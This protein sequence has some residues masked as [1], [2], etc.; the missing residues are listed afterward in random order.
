MAQPRRILIVRLSHLGDV[1]HALPV[2]HALRE[3]HPDAEFGW[4][5]QPEFASLLEGLPGLEQLF[6]FERQKGLS[7]WIKIGREIR[8]WKP[9]L[10]V[11]CQGNLKSAAVTRIS[12]APR[13]AG[14]HRY[15]WREQAGARVLTETAYRVTKQPIHALDR[16][17]QLARRFASETKLRTDPDLTKAELDRGR[18]AWREH[19]GETGAL[20]IHLSTQSDVRSWPTSSAAQLARSAAEAGRA[21]LLL[22]G[23]AEENEGRLLAQELDGLNLIHHWAGQSGLRDLA[24]LFH[25]AAEDDARLVACDSGPMH[26]AVACGLNVLCLSGP[27]DASRTGPRQLS[28]VA[29]FS[30]HRVLRTEE[31]LECAPCLK[32]TCGHTE[33]PVCMTRIEP[34]LVLRAL[35]RS[36]LQA[37]ES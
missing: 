29:P 31:K 9:D 13:R 19:G 8:R 30:D 26:L 28:Q 24:G 5:I 23:P 36:S 7:A 25:A 20:L 22:S 3:S 4:A 33:G 11:D 21:V 2:Y 6:Y 34:E 10:T 17:E 32:R 37:Q 12:G 27:Q 16:V 15:D 18:A 1:V 35:E 14:Y